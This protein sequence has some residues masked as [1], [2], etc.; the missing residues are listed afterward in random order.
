MDHL[1]GRSVPALLLGTL[2]IAALHALIPSHWLAFALVG[3]AQRWPMHRTLRITVLAG[4]GHALL[5]MVLG[6]LV[7]GA[8]KELQHA[9]PP[10]LEHA[11]TGGILVLL[12]LY[13]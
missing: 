4:S 9:I 12:G 1:N 5:T 3:R 7:A 10:Q 8:G 11:A 6:L 13:F 2:T